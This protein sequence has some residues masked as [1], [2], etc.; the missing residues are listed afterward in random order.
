[1]FCIILPPMSSSDL[2]D[3][4]STTSNEAAIMPKP[5]MCDVMINVAKSGCF[6]IVDARKRRF[7]ALKGLKLVVEGSIGTLLVI[8]EHPSL[9][10]LRRRQDYVCD[11]RHRDVQRTRR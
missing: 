11:D 8:I 3:A 10:L 6:P 4:Q 1:M 7:R 9:N 5:R 2:E